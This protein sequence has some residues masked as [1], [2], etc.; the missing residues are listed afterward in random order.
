M[1]AEADL[2]P[3]CLRGSRKAGPPPRAHRYHPPMRATLPLLLLLLG[4]CAA[5]TPPPPVEPEEEPPGAPVPE[6]FLGVPPA[7]VAGRAVFD[8]ESGDPER[9]AR[10]RRVLLALDAEALDTWI[11]KA[12]AAPPGSPSRA[13][14]LAVLA[15]RGE[16]LDGWPPAEVVGMC[17]AEIAGDGPGRRSTMLSLAR[18]RTLGPAAIPPLETAAR[19]GG[20]RGAV[21]ERVLEVLGPPD[22]DSR[23]AVP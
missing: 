19:E 20:R 6:V 2:P 5:T 10:A 17:L 4:G 1:A 8:L 11:V 13:A 7:V 15:E 3:A 18:L 16:S 9:A 21:A 12:S 23:G 14:L 22:R